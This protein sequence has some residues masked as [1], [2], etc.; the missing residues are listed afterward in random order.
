MKRISTSILVLTISLA[1]FSQEEKIKTGWNFGAL[2]AITYST[3]LGFQY[4]AVVNLFDYGDG[5][6]YP[7][8]NQKFYIEVSRFTKGSSIYRLMYETKTLIPG[9]SITSDL[10]YLTDQAYDFYG[11]NGYDAVYNADWTDSDLDADIYKSRLF[12]NTD[13]KLFRFKN[14]VKGKLAGEY[15]QWNAGLELKNF[16]FAPVNIEKLNEGRDEEDRLPDIPGLYQNYINWGLI[17][18]DEAQGGFITT[19]KA[20]ITYDSRDFEANAMKGIWFETGVEASPSFLSDAGFAKFFAIYRQYFTL[21]PKDLSFA[22]RLGYQTT[23]GGN[24]PW[25]RQ[26]QIITSVL[27]GT[28]SEGLGGSKN[29]RGVLRNRIVGDGLFYANAEFRWKAVRFSLINQ[30]FYIG[31]VGFSDFGMVTKK[32]DIEIP[33]QA[34]MPEGDQVGDYFNPD[35]EKMHISAGGGL[36]VAMNEN[37]IISADLGKTLNKQDGNIGFYIG[38]N[39]LF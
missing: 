34:S 36:R 23:I 6:K 11:F 31:F 21:I 35:N 30:N 17:G 12:Y 4:G 37:F 16:E 9:L 15:F 10:A 8:Y 3:D 13:R 5:S 25:Y 38:L 19:L 20:G 18:P 39:Y 14:D 28:T 26:N 1:A 32:T 33:D 24:V 22:Y 29:V 27:A 2:P 7:V